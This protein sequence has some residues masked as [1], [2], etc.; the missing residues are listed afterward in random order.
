MRIS[1]VFYRR[2]QVTGVMCPMIASSDKG[3]YGNVWNSVESPLPWPLPSHLGQTFPEPRQHIP[4]KRLSPAQLNGRQFTG[5]QDCRCCEDIGMLRQLDEV[6]IR[7]V[8]AMALPAICL[9]E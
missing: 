4:R 3:L 2:A 8:L 9:D 7:H 5:N 1:T 6:V